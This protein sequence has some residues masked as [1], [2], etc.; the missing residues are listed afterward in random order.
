MSV[1]SWILV[2]V[3]LWSGASLAA[4]LFAS[5]ISS[6][7]T[8]VGAT[9]M[10]AWHERSIKERRV[11]RSTA[12]LTALDTIAQRPGVARRHVVCT[13]PPVRNVERTS[14]T[15]SGEYLDTTAKYTL[16]PS[17]TS[18]TRRTAGGTPA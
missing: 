17:V 14:T 2:I 18:K 9:L 12:T 6:L 4:A 8:P 1:L 5:R 11:K 15:M 7:A 13:A 10:A 16:A 3:C